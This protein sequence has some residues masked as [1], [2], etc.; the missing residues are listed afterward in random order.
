MANPEHLAI[1]K[2]GVEAWNDWRMA[3]PY[4][5]P[6]LSDGDLTEAGSRRARLTG[7]DFKGVKLAG[8]NLAGAV[9]EKANLLR[10]NLH[11]ATLRGADLREANLEAA[12]L[13]R[14]NLREVNLSGAHLDRADLSAAD[15]QWGYLS[16]RSLRGSS[17]NQ[18]SLN[19]ANFT[20]AD[21]SGARLDEAKLG[22]TILTEADL[23]E[24]SLTGAVANGTYFV[25]LDLRAAKGIEAVVHGAPSRVGIDTIYKSKGKIPEVFLRGCGVPDEFIIYMNSLVGRPIE[26]YS[27]FISYSTKDQEFAERLHADLQARGVRCWFAPHDIKGGEIVLD[28]IDAA[29]RFHDKVLLIL[30]EDSVSSKWVRLELRKAFDRGAKEDKRVLFPVRVVPFSKLEEWKL[31]ESDGTDLAEEVRKYFIPDFSNWKDHDS[32]QKALTRLVADLKAESR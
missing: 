27:C 7:V 2:Q 21:L 16:G 28:Q 22:F 12:D 6:D 30:S 9:L 11:H 26:Y 3:S 8:A 23:H 17:L 14:A 25:G 1:L 4:V 29:I 20:A 19:W 32:Y 31:V 10:V 18:A 24:A 5:L 13:R 15:L